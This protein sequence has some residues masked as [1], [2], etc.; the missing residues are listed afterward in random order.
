MN[1]NVVPLK[2]KSI[3]KPLKT[4]KNLKKS[5]KKLWESIVRSFNLEE[6]DLVLLHALCECADRKDQAEKELSEYGSLTFKVQKKGVA[7]GKEELK[8]H[9]AV[10]ILRDC[11]VILS[12]LRRELGLSEPPDESRPPR[13]PRR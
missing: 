8:P 6:H 3:K 4:P 12:R 5:G 11:G 2:L 13:M 10:A 7:E 9:P 1:S